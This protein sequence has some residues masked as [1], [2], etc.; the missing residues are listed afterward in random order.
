M[1]T[2][3]LTH[4]N[5]AHLCAHNDLHQVQNA[6]TPMKIVSHNTAPNCPLTLQKR[7]GAMHTSAFIHSYLQHTSTMHKYTTSRGE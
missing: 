3:M 2:D 6:C 7:A 4:E 5:H 1:C